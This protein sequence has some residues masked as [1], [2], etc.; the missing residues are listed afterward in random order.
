M[1]KRLIE[2]FT[3]SKKGSLGYTLTELLVVI[4]IIA[5][6]CAIAIPSVI[7]ISRSLRFKQANDYAKSIFLAAQ[8]NLTDMRAQGGLYS[9]ATKAA[10]E[11]LRPNDSF[12]GEYKDEYF[13]TS[14]TRS[15][16]LMVLPTGSVDASLL[17]DQVIVEYNPYTG[18]V[19]SVF[20]CAKKD[21]QLLEAYQKTENIRDK[22]VRK[23]M[24]IGYYDGSGLNSAQIELEDTAAQVEFLNEQEGIVRITIPMPDAFYSTFSF[25]DFVEALRIKLTITGEMELRNGGVQTQ[26]LANAEGASVG[27]ERAVSFDLP[28]QSEEN[29]MYSVSVDGRSVVVE[30]PIDSLVDYGSFAN[31]ALKTSQIGET[32]Q[33]GIKANQKRVSQIANEAEFVI[34]PGENVTIQADV[35]FEQS[36]NIMVNI[37]SGILSGVNPMFEYLQP[38]GTEGKYV[39]GVANGRNLQNLN[40]LAPS[41]AKNVESVVFTSDIYWNETVSYYNKEY[42]SGGNYKNDTEEAPVR[43]LPY[44][45]P[46]H[47]E[48]LFGTAS[49]NYAGT[50]ERTP[51]LSDGEDSAEHASI[52]GNVVVDGEA[53]RGARVYYLN[54]DAT[55]YDLGKRYYVDQSYTT[56]M[57]RD[58]AGLFGYV[59]TTIDNI[60]VVNPIVK[61]KAFTTDN[62]P[63]TGALVGAAGK[64][65]YIANCSTYIDKDEK[66]FNSAM[67]RQEYYNA[68][69]AQGWY[70]VSGEGAVGGLVGYAKSHRT[71][72]GALSDNQKVL[73]FNSCFAAVNVSG[74]MREATQQ[75]RDVWDFIGSFLGQIFY[76]YGKDYG[77]TNGV[78][79]LIGNSELTNF[80]KCY[81][82]GN[83]M[84][85]NTNGAQTFTGAITS[86]A[87]KWLGVEADFLYRGRESV[88]AG[89]FVGTSHGTRYTNCFASG[90]VSAKNKSGD[91]KSQVGAGGFVGIMCIDESIDYGTVSDKGTNYDQHSVF[92]SCYSVGTVTMNGAKESNFSGANARRKLSLNSIAGN[93]Q[94]I[95]SYAVADYY[96]LLP[97][98]YNDTKGK[99]PSYESFY[100]F[101]DA[102]YLSG[103]YKEDEVQD[104]YNNCANAITYDDLVSLSNGV[105]D[106]FVKGRLKEIKKI[107]GYE[108]IFNKNEKLESVCIGKLK[109]A[110]AREY[111]RAAD[112]NTTFGYERSG[113]YPFP[114]LTGM[115]YYGNWPF[116][117]AEVGLGYY[118]DYAE[119]D[120]G[121]HY[122]YFDRESSS[123]LTTKQDDVVIKDG[124]AIFAAE[125]KTIKV[126]IQKNEFKLQKAD[127]EI[128]TSEGKAY[129]VFLLTDEVMQAATKYT[130]EHPDQ[131]YVPVTVKQDK[132]EYTFYFNP[133]VARSQLFEGEAQPEDGKPV[134]NRFYIRSARQFAALEKMSSFWGAD[135]VYEQQLNLDATQYNWSETDIN[136]EKDKSVAVSS[137]GNVDAPFAATYAASYMDANSNSAKYEIKGM[138][139]KDAGFFGVIGENGTVR[140]VIISCPGVTAKPDVDSAAVLAGENQGTISGVELILGGGVQIKA[141]ENAGILAGKTSGSITDCKV[142]EEKNQSVHVT[143]EAKYVGG[144]VGTVA[145]TEQNTISLDQCSLELTGELKLKGTEAAGGFVGAA[146]KVTADTVGVS[147]KSLTSS[148]KLVGG[149]VGNAEDTTIT[150]GVLNLTNELA[151]TDE[152]SVA[153]GAAAQTS[154]S[155]FT[156]VQVTLNSLSGGSAAG[157][158][159]TA[160]DV[161]LDNCQV[162]LTG[163]ITGTNGA[164]GV[165]GETSGTGS[166]RA[167]NGKLGTGVTSA[168]GQAA[169]FA[170]NLKAGTTVQSC[171]VALNNTDIRA[172]KQAAGFAISV[173]ESVD[174]SS[175]R[176]KGSVSSTDAEAEAEAAGY[177]IDIAANVSNSYV[178]PAVADS[179]YQGNG[180]GNLTISGTNAAGF[181]LRVGKGKTV[182]NCYTLGTIKGEQ[183]YG[184]AGSNGGTISKSIANVDLYGTKQAAAFVGSNEGSVTTSY[185]WYD[186]NGATALTAMGGK[187]VNSYFANLDGL[188]IAKESVTV[189]GAD[190]TGTNVKPETLRGMKLDGF[191][192]PGVLNAYPYEADLYENGK[193]SYPYPMLRDHYGDWITPPQYAYG[194]AYY[195]IYDDDSFKLHLVDLSDQEKT[196]EGT[197]FNEKK[198]IFDAS[199]TIEDAGYAV[200]RQESDSKLNNY[201]GDWIKELEHSST[202]NGTTINYSFFKLNDQGLAT[203]AGKKT[204]KVDTRF[205]D[206]FDVTD[207]IYQVRTA[208]QLANIGEVK[209]SFKQ[210]H[211][212]VATDFVTAA[213]ESGK[214]YDG[215]GRKLTVTDQ[216]Q[217]WLDVSGTVQELELEVLASKGTA[218]FGTVGGNVSLNAVTMGQAA[219]AQPQEAAAQ[220]QTD[221]TSGTTAPT[222]PAVPKFALAEAVSGNLNVGSVT[223]NGDV[224]TFIGGNAAK[225]TINGAT[226]VTGNVGTL[227]AGGTASLGDV[228]VGGNVTGGLI[229]TTVGFTAENVTVNGA[230]NGKL[231]GTASGTVSLGTV[232]VGSIGEAGALIGTAGKTATIGNITVN[233][234]LSGKLVNVVAGTVSGAEVSAVKAQNINSLFGEV[235]KDAKV[236][237]FNIT[238]GSMAAP[239]VGGELEGALKDVTV[240]AGTVSDAQGVLAATSSGTIEG[241]GVNVTAVTVS[242]DVFGGLVGKVTGGSLTDNTVNAEKITYTLGDKDVSIGGLVGEMSGGT[243][244]DTSKATT[245]SG[246][247]QVEVPE[248]TQNAQ[249]VAVEEESSAVAEAAAEEGAEALDDKPVYAIG[250]AVGKIIAGED[251]EKKTTLATIRNVSAAVEIYATKEISATGQNVA[252]IGSFLGYAGAGT[253]EKCASTEDSSYEFLG[254][255]AK[256]TKNVDGE[257][258]QA[259]VK[260]ENPFNFY[261]DEADDGA[262]DLDG[263]RL[264]AV[265]E[266]ATV[267][268]VV[269]DLSECTCVYNGKDCNVEYGVDTYYYGIS[270]RTPLKSYTADTTQAVTSSFVEQEVKFNN[271]NCKTELQPTGFY[272]PYPVANENTVYYKAFAKCKKSFL[273]YTEKFYLCDAGENVELYCKTINNYSWNITVT[274]YQPTEPE[275]SGTYL[276]IDTDGHILNTSG[277]PYSKK[278]IKNFDERHELTGYMWSLENQKVTGILGAAVV[279]YAEDTNTSGIPYVKYTVEKRTFQLY[280]VSVGASNVSTLTFTRSDVADYK[281][282]FVICEPVA[283]SQEASATSE[284]APAGE[285]TGGETQNNG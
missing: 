71:T 42:G 156:G 244:G 98:Y 99:T 58:F 168:E 110:Y 96:R 232:E 121:L 185:G 65:V 128:F 213:I 269:V 108:I 21:V 13:V 44:F 242:T 272:Y 171:T 188:L 203:V 32:Q 270:A 26:S 252:T 126:T 178:T 48:S 230:L 267:P 227:V 249:A 174:G 97:L 14:N 169:G 4:G 114:I 136:N 120:T 39:L 64:N 17:S 16:F 69:K 275:I 107:R 219:S 151:A 157:F 132:I 147:A 243:L 122:Y 135:Y 190:G 259:S 247:I 161:K 1:R 159:Y 46:I 101:K 173:G 63:A 248:Q 55:E 204:V 202:I 181:A 24:L 145:G 106:E 233:D 155:S 54:I 124:Y 238:V 20:Y 150:S 277:E 87:A 264:T 89:G 236:E 56:G 254:G 80:Y 180:N 47:N 66:N 134:Q 33:Y 271:K 209:A 218:V 163:G 118:E 166:L 231:V 253:L 117:T 78:G 79:G 154:G 146:S 201:C 111:W 53:A 116:P 237:N 239:L 95:G 77:Y 130:E 113:N 160:E 199:G 5:I 206:A 72:N 74:N 228:T 210:T 25:Q 152:A 235:Q 266:N 11:A 207:G 217:K 176:G 36:K 140:D 45:V 83:V 35:E 179:D 276:A 229:G 283:A 224:D 100:I 3:K 76:G 119:K 59:N 221:S 138:T 105:S 7:A 50:G 165:V 258:W 19:Y 208:K 29:S 88:G 268:Y 226:E 192:N 68:E 82:S 52:V 182:N 198:D 263:A 205:A 9:L 112:G 84:A 153:G 49:F 187:C 164:A 175:V 280:P 149:L 184:F 30:Y 216:K 214:T 200:F 167:V 255:Y 183:V 284:I 265:G 282:Q 139:P 191:K 223:V 142:T 34:L 131:F 225:V 170:L 172:S 92:T 215:C 85:T 220:A 281:R 278:D 75:T 177:A 91:S 27:T 285:I 250:G 274:L 31:L 51:V 260:K 86:N 257:L 61:G 193:A 28:T 212:I 102:Y 10:S 197:K 18:N 256:T 144:L 40:A 115:P 211:D 23:A 234:A 15:S 251:A 148:A 41:I 129:H 103:Y 158:A 93:A 245:V 195:E 38:S 222:T 162:S 6:V 189:Y 43:A 279:S 67:M 90:N 262:Y 125:K 2:K 8:Q 94:E 127:S 240:K 81:A 22:A 186:D 104:N 12:P 109:E 141:K 60:H 70:G 73:A 241:C 133:N 137:I 196:V 123:Q 194:V 37:R 261:S 246:K 62:N 273:G 57:D 143:L